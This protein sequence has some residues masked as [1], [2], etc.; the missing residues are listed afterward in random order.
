MDEFEQLE[1]PAGMFLETIWDENCRGA[2]RFLTSRAQG[3][4][5]SLCRTNKYTRRAGRR[6]LID[7]LP[8]SNSG[9]SFHKQLPRRRTRSMCLTSDRQVAA[10][11]R[12]KVLQLIVH[13]I[14]HERD[15]AMHEAVENGPQRLPLLG[16]TCS[17]PEQ[18]GSFL[19]RQLPF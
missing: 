5:S 1:T 7:Q 8:Q 14:T 2:A 19:A 18:V 12:A 15:Y 11:L 9:F 4:S 10:S 16:V 6:F 17:N 3:L 13:I